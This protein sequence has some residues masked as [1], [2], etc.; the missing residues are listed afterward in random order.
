[1]LQSQVVE[2]LNAARCQGLNRDT[3]ALDFDLKPIRKA[4]TDVIG[5]FPYPQ[6]SRALFGTDQL[7]AIESLQKRYTADKEAGQ[8][9][10]LDSLGWCQITPVLGLP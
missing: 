7:A 3:L 8:K 2:N 10:Y 6:F 9:R 5:Q 4:V 1:L